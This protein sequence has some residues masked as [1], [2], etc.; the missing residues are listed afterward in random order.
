[1]GIFLGSVDNKVWKKLE[2]NKRF[3]ILQYGLAIMEIIRGK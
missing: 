3:S 1:M 2:D